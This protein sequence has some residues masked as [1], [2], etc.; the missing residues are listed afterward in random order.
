MWVFYAVY[1][2]DFIS[3]SFLI[4]YNSFIAILIYFIFMMSNPLVGELK[5]DHDSF[6]IIMDKGVDKIKK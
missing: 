4:L 6:Q 2:R 3:I 1:D 5:M